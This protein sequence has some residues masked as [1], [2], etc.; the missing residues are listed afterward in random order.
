MG[1]SYVVFENEMYVFV[2]PFCKPF[3]FKRLQFH[4]TFFYRGALYSG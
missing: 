1:V 3:V 4:E 2:H